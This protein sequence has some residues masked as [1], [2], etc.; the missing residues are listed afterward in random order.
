[1]IDYIKVPNQSPLFD[2]EVLTNGYQD[3]AVKLVM[4]WVTAQDVPNLSMKLVSEPGKTPVVFIE[5]TGE[6]KTDETILMYGHLDKQPP[7]LEGW[8][9]GTGPYSP[10]II[11]GKLYGRGGADDG[12]A[13]FASIT[14]IKAL[15][16][17]KIPHARIV[18]LVE[19]CEESGSLDLPFYID[20]LEKDIGTPSLVICLDSGCGNYDQLWLT[21]TLRGMLYGILTVSVSSEGVH[22]GSGSGIIPSSFRIMRQLLDRIEDSATGKILLKSLWADIPDEHVQYA[23]DTAAVLGDEVVNS[24]PLLS[25]VKT[26]SNDKAELLLN[27]CWRPTLSYT[28]IGGIP[29]L[30]NPGNV[31]RP[32]T[33][34]GLS[35]R[36]PPVTDA[37]VVRA[38]LKKVLESNPPEGAHVTFDAPKAAAGWKAPKMETWLEDAVQSASKAVFNKP[39][40]V[41]GEGGSIPFMGMLGKKFPKTQFIIAGV[42]GPKSNAHGP[43]EFLHIDYF[44]KLTVSVAS[45]IQDHYKAKVTTA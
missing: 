2:K 3:Q 12:Y 31:L 20:L 40:L 25:G 23:K 37:D 32:S 38:E 33:S 35:F 8:I 42:L 39:C 28:A 45:L 15:K 44:H 19:L 13:T 27:K 11:D 21:A 14:A 18:M 7:M 34:I 22:S 1:M 16:A 24:Y 10:A 9:E 5:I 29:P 4:D 41:W 43:N 26:M 6:G 30:A 36:L 17:Q